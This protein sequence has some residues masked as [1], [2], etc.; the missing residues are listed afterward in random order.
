MRREERGGRGEERRGERER[1]RE[2]WRDGKSGLEVI[3]LLL[4]LSIFAFAFNV[5]QNQTRRTS[6]VNSWGQGA[7]TCMGGGHAT[8]HLGR[9]E[10]NFVELILSFPRHGFLVIQLRVPG[11]LSDTSMHSFQG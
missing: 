2:R 6:F 8:A 9:L 3:S 7:C 11:F 1:E 5:F 10:A 4:I